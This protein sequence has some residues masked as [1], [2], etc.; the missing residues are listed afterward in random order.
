M[1]FFLIIAITIIGS[2]ALNILPAPSSMEAEDN[3]ND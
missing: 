3:L 2:Y 1:E